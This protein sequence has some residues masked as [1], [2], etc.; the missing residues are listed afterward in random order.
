MCGSK[1]IPS[2][3]TSSMLRGRTQAKPTALLP[4]IG[5]YE[6]A[7]LSRVARGVEIPS[8]WR[9]PVFARNQRWLLEMTLTDG[10]LAALDDRASTSSDGN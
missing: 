9:H 1:S 3:R 5:P 8:L 4:T 7:P 10:S 2:T 6:I